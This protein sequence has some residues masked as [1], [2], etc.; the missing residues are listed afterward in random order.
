MV[1]TSAVYL[2]PGWGHVE[3]TICVQ[4]LAFPKRNLGICLTFPGT[5]GCMFLWWCLCT[6]CL[7][8]CQMRVTV[9]LC[10]NPF[11]GLCC[12]VRVT[13]IQSESAPLVVD[14][15]PKHRHKGASFRTVNYYCFRLL[16]SS[17]I[18]TFRFFSSSLSFWVCVFFCCCCER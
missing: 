15:F 3:L 5:R 4:L 10:L 18:E 7:L 2:L 14:F 16:F 12:C 11:S 1:T 6:V 9:G 8:V 17:F 13:Y